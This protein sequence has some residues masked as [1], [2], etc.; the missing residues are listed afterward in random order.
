MIALATERTGA[1]LPRSSRR[2]PD[3]RQLERLGT[4]LCLYRGGQGGELAGWTQAAHAVACAT[5]DGD[6]L[7][8]SVCF[9]DR[10]GRCC[11]RLFLL[12][13][14]DFLAWDRLVAQL[15]A[16]TR[17]DAAGEP[18]WRRLASR[19]AGTGWQLCALRLH[20]LHQAGVDVLA[21]SPAAVSPLGAAVARRI[22]RRHGA[23]GQV[24]TKSAAPGTRDGMGHRAGG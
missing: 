17:G 5:I 24:P 22:A 15:P 4:V 9:H 20:V 6:G 1:A 21:G 7:C 3:P 18:L 10:R 12:P 2:L 11:W 14:S 13:D 16:Q 19:V 23:T 8:E